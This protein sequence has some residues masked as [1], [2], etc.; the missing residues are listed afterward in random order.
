MKILTR[1]GRDQHQSTVSKLLFHWIKFFHWRLL[2]CQGNVLVAIVQVHVNT[3][4]VKI[5][6]F[7]KPFT[8]GAEPSSFFSVM[9]F[10]NLTVA[11]LPKGFKLAQALRRR[12]LHCTCFTSQCKI[13]NE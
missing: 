2:R 11:K 9:I 7:I 3:F 5:L 10:E 12:I 4:Q 1:L 8:L 6:M 13:D